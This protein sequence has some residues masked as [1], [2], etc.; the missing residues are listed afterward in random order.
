MK[1]TNEEIKKMEDEKSIMIMEEWD[2]VN[3]IMVNEVRFMNMSSFSRVHD[4]MDFFIDF[5]FTAHMG[6]DGVPVRIFKWE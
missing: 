2:N 4:V 5:E 1:I 3:Q 6:W